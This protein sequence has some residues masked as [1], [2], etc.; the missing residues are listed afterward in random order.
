MYLEYIKDFLPQ[1]SHHKFQHVQ[2]LIRRCSMNFSQKFELHRYQ[3]AMERSGGLN[4]GKAA[5]SDDE[6]QYIAML[7]YQSLENHARKLHVTVLQ[8]I[9]EFWQGI[10]N[11]K[12]KEELNIQMERIGNLAA[13]TRTLYTTMMSTFLFQSNKNWFD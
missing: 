7:E 9:K 8:E 3:R 12:T 11:S 4:R 13:E 2:Y 1:V 6:M 10:R 5:G